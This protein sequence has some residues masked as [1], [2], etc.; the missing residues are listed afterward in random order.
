MTTIHLVRHG[1]ASLGAADYDQLSALGTRQAA[2]LGRWWQQIGLQ[3]DAVVAGGLKRHGQSA[4]ACLAA[5]GRACEVSIDPG[6]DEFDG[7]D[8]LR[9]HRPDLGDAQAVRRFLDQAA[10]PARAFQAAFGAAVQRW[11][12]GAHDADYAQ[13][14]PAFRHRVLAALHAQVQAAAHA[15]HASV[16][17]FTSGG[18]IAVACQAALGVPDAHVLDLNWPLFNA[19][20]TQLRAGAGGLRLRHFNAVPH[21]EVVREVALLT[22]R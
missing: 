13:P 15:G 9:V 3:P 8:I 20:V 18:P 4:H 19:G 22:H 21:L 17:V 6:F 2:L 12:G 16:A 14:W 10:H 1:Q 11:V 7:E 5:M